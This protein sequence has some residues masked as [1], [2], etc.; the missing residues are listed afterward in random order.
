VSR[1]SPLFTRVCL[2]I[3]CV[4]F[5]LG[6]MGA[7]RATPRRRAP[8]RVPRRAVQRTYASQ[9]A[10]YACAVVVDA[11]TGKVLFEKSP[12]V[13][14]A[15]ASL[16]KM[17]T[18]LLTL[19]ALERGLISLQDTVTTPAEVRQVRGSRVRLRPGE[20]IPLEEA[21]RAMA[22]SSANDA[23]LTVAHHVAGSTERFVTLMNLR[24]N[25]LGMVNTHYVNPHGLDDSR[26]AGSRTTARDQSIL[27]RELIRHPLALEFSSTVTDTIRGGQVIHT[28]NRLLG[29][30]DGVDG[31]K[32]GYT[33]K[34]GFCLVS[35][36]RRGEMRVIS[37]LLGARSNRRRFSESA[38]LLTQIF[39]RFH[40]VSV[41][42]KGQDVDHPCTIMGGDPPQIRLVAGEDVAVLLPATNSR[43]ITVEVDAPLTLQPP[44]PEGQTLGQIRV[45]V[46]DSLAAE[47][48]AVA[49]RATHRATLLDRIDQ[50][51]D[52]T[53]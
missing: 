16:T 29:R 19:E 22:I 53:P 12:D 37:V 47:V 32:T 51:F 52:H 5:G 18:E 38:G 3:L 17:M 46:G 6:S 36:A 42:R 48:P 31:L 23:A 35:T 27:A 28:T 2:L 1:M 43:A 44:F 11:E 39:S 25:E 4:L 26:Q 9:A 8:R 21:M 13:E 49:S 7:G 33:G 10:S 15:P 41:I 34:A 40:K 50:Y 30:C 24:A 20:R 45:L 14:R